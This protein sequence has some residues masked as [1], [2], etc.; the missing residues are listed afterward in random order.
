MTTREQAHKVLDELPESE[1]APVLEFIASRREGDIVDE[2][3]N[4]GAMLD[5]A[6]DGMLA[7]MDAEEDQARPGPGPAH[8]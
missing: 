3:G 6:A 2:W 7:E 1:L 5:D 4:L 8:S